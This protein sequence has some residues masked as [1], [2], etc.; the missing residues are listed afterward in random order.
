MTAVADS[1]AALE[2]AGM[3][4]DCSAADTLRMA[5]LVGS[6]G[7]MQL[8]AGV[9]LAEWTPACRS[10]DRNAWYPGWNFCNSRRNA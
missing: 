9:V 8:E 10:W 2:A 5:Q 3:L 6:E 7:M 4:A 1:L